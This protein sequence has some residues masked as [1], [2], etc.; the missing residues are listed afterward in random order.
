LSARP[1]AAGLQQTSCPIIGNPQS[2]VKS[3]YGQADRTDWFGGR[4]RLTPATSSQN[5]FVERI[6]RMSTR[7]FPSNRPKRFFS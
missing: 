6:K 1:A 7:D 3:F 2:R 5:L 4:F